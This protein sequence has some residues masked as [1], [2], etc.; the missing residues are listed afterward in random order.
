MDGNP[1]VD[2][3]AIIVGAGPAGLA[4]AATMRQL[5]LKAAILEKA[6]T[7][8]SVWRRHYDRLHLHT[9]R[10][11]SGLPG[12]AMPRTY[13]RYPS[14]AQVVEYLENYAAHFDLRP[15]F[16]ST[17]RTVRRDGSTW[18]VDTEQRSFTAPVVVIA[19]GWADFPHLPTW[20]G[21]DA[22]KGSVI[23]STEYNHPAAY[24]GKRVLV[25][26]FGNSGGEIALDLAQ[27]N[28][29]VTLAVR[30]P[31]RILPRELLG[32][33]I[34]TW[35][36]AEARLPARVADFINAPAIRLAVGSVK[37]LGLKMASKGP[38]RMIEEDQ[39][40][41]LL[42]VGTLARIRD[43]TIK[44]RGGIDRF[45]SDGV[46]FSDTPAETFDCIILATGFRPDL[47]RLL[48]EAKGVFD[49]HG[50]P[51]A[52]GRATL[53]P[54]LLFCGLI[55]SPTGQLREIGIEAQ[56]IARLVKSYLPG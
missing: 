22:Y 31:V 40:V 51:L 17:V 34:L 46:V 11:H 3:D 9:D 15:Q 10:G 55:A 4:C 45:T 14:R 56:R 13:P 44:V 54:G 27:A 5:G 33:P 38:R 47:R 37:H 36:I 6:D 41:P 7:V 19:T 8:G 1:M 26:G 48:P 18:R 12:M 23:H 20:P 43:G 16:N 25:V 29:D 2:A 24:A 32:L 50:M 35:A 39:R 52:T 49:R 28:V 42:D 53:E 30:G 21:S